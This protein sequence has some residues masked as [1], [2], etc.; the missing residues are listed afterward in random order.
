M[1][2]LSCHPSS[3]VPR[4][5][6]RQRCEVGAREAGDVGAL[7]DGVLRVGAPRSFDALVVHGVGHLAVRDLPKQSAGRR[8][9]HETV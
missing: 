1:S 4:Q 8:L 6:V 9:E 2:P 5:H 3:G 7:L